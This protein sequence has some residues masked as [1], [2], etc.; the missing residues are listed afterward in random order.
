MIQEVIEIGALLIIATI[1]I[2]IAISFDINKWLSRRD[3]RRE[4][5][6]RHLCPHATV[7]IL[8]ED[9]FR[10]RSLMT[11]PPGTSVCICSRCGTQTHD[12]NL[13]QRVVN[14]YSKNLKML[15]DDENKFSKYVKKNFGI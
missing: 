6:A 11:S 15:L 9:K 14:S 3:K 10:V 13:A 12:I 2:K 5:K 1:A 7:D 4:E 8:Y